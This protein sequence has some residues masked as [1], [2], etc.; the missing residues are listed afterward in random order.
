MILQKDFTK[1]DLRPFI[2][3][4]AKNE[5]YHSPSISLDYHLEQIKKFESKEQIRNFYLIIHSL[6]KEYQ[7]LFWSDE[8]RKDITKWLKKA[9][10]FF[11]KGLPD[12]TLVNL[13]DTTW[14]PNETLNPN[15]PEPPKENV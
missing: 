6:C 14:L 2:I 9:K 10:G 5:G 1:A 15:E 13:F 7:D 12:G 3:E 11:L 4:L 8:H